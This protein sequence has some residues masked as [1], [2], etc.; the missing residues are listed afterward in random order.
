MI[1]CEKKSFPKHDNGQHNNT[2][3]WD[4]INPIKTPQI[5][6]FFNPVPKPI[7]LANK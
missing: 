1:K 5:N 2:A 6:S 3:E 4:H 7:N